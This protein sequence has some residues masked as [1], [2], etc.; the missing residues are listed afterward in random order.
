MRHNKIKPPKF[1]EWI[2]RRTVNPEVEFSII[3]DFEEEY[4]EIAVS[5]NRVSA[6][7]WYWGMVFISIIPFIVNSMYWSFTMFRNYMKIAF[8]NILK[9]KSYSLINIAGL[10]LGMA[11]FILI[12]LYVQYEMS[13][14]SYHNNSD[15]IF[16]LVREVEYMGGSGK[17]YRAN[18]GAPVPELLANNFPQMKMY[19]KLCDSSGLMKYN[20]NF[21]MEPDVFYAD[22]DFLKIFSFS[23]KKGNPETALK[24]PN[25]VIITEEMAEKY[26]AG[27]D[28]VGKVINYENRHDLLVTGVIKNVPGN[29]HISFDFL[30]SFETLRS[31]R[32]EYFFTKNWDTRVWTYAV[33]PEEVDEKVLGTQVTDF[34]SRHTSGD[35]YASLNFRF[36]PVRD[37]HLHSHMGVEVKANSDITYIYMFIIIAFVILVIACINF[38]NLSTA[39]SSTRAM[40]VGVRKTFGAHVPQLM[41]QF[42]GETL[43]ISFFSMAAALVLIKFILPY[44]NNLAEKE[45]I[46]DS[47]NFLMFLMV[48]AG[49]ALLTGGLSGIYPALFLSLMRPV[50]ILKG[51]SKSG[52]SHNSFRKVLVIVQFVFSIVLIISTIVIYGQLNF[53][54]NKNLGFSEKNVLTIPMRG[55]RSLQELYPSLKNELLSNSNI[56]GVTGSSTKPGTGDANGIFISYEGI[57]KETQSSVV[58]INYDYLKTLE[59][60]LADGRDFLPN[61]QNAFL[62]NEAAAK[63]HG[64]EKAEGTKLDF[65]FRGGGK[66]KQ[67]YSGEIVGTVKDFHYKSV[68]RKISPTVFIVDP[69]RMNYM[70]VKY[71]PGDVLGTISFIKKTWEKFVPGRPFEFSFLE[72]DI[73]RVYH[74]EEKLGNIFTYFA[75]LAIFI[76]SL[77][78]FGLA[79]FTAERRTKEIAVRKV[80]GASAGKIVILLSKE[81]LKL[82]LLASILAWP[83]AFF[84]T[85]SWL[86]DFPYRIGLSPVYFLLASA[87]AV[88]IALLTVSYQA[89]RSA[90]ANPVKALKYE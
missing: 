49:T 76:A 60:G 26:F 12:I 50:Q 66:I 10:A 29:S 63:L 32:N 28:P 75:V 2:L 17:Y 61:E 89:V 30:I 67:M 86:Q 21:F 33:V 4:M 84:L 87:L 15:R 65:Y 27:T 41:R 68:E 48:A 43:L 34:L 56:Q 58:Y 54:R 19:G 78:L 8:R 36:Q 25:S 90:A 42:F 5:K 23:F 64:W 13:Y 82:V 85:R 73:N 11:C 24:N 57:K 74:A 44:F 39:R 22:P 37:I 52:T 7:Y 83:A 80:L 69:G 35:I 6:L 70:A 45:I 81:F 3:G 38:M 62:V 53:M 71:K 9:F 47:G 46:I 59:I 51:V 1:A 88:L 18:T 77:G 55:M 31:L 14:D 20:R 79:A 72:E 40:E 16:R